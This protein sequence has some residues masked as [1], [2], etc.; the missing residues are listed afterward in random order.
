MVPEGEYRG[1]HGWPALVAPVGEEG[2]VQKPGISQRFRVS[3][4]TTQRPRVK[5]CAAVEVQPD[6]YQERRLQ[7]IQCLP[8]LGSF[9]NEYE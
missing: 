8:G 7:N 4:E 1:Q 2:N 3:L 5:A 9:E 6:T